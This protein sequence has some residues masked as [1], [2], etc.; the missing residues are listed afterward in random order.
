MLLLVLLLLLMLLLFF[1]GIVEVASR[2]LR[3]EGS[4]QEIHQFRVL[5]L[6]RLLWPRFN[7]TVVVTVVAVAGRVVQRGLDEFRG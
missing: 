5:V 2:Q 4:V 3:L 7:A 1:A 6:Q